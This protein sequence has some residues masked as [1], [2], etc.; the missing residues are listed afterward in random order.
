M[1]RSPMQQAH[2]LRPPPPPSA[3]AYAADITDEFIKPAV[4]GD[5]AGLRDGDALLF[6]NFR[7]DRMREIFAASSSRTSNAFARP[8]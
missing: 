5:Y 7:S 1:P 3:A 6:F 2:A 4:I 8:R